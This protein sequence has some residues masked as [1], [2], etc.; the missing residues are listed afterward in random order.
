MGQTAAEAS[1]PASLKHSTDRVRPKRYASAAGAVA[2]V[3]PT[4]PQASFTSVIVPSS[5]VA[6]LVAILA[7]DIAIALR[8]PTL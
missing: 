1:R 7:T 5:P 4:L 3:G 8:F 2:T 6:S